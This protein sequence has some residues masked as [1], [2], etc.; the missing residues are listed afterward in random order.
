MKDCPGSLHGTLQ[1]CVLVLRTLHT[2]VHVHASL[3][4]Q[5][6]T[7]TLPFTLPSSLVTTM[8]ISNVYFG[9]YITAYIHA[10]LRMTSVIAITFCVWLYL[11]DMSPACHCTLTACVYGIYPIAVYENIIYRF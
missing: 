4:I 1:T 10:V 2:C 11:S 9:Q 8:C 3:N 5:H 6:C 7:L